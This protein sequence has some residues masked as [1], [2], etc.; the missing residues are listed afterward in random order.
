M[1]DENKVNR[2]RQM[3]AGGDNGTG[4]RDG[5][6]TVQDMRQAPSKPKFDTAPDVTKL[7]FGVMLKIKF[8]ALKSAVQH[9][10]LGAYEGLKESAKLSIRKERMDRQEM[11]AVPD[12]DLISFAGK[13]GDT[14]KVLT[15]QDFTSFS[16]QIGNLVDQSKVKNQ[17]DPE[18]F[19][20]NLRDVMKKMTYSESKSFSIPFLRKAANTFDEQSSIDP[21]RGMRKQATDILIAE[22]NRLKDPGGAREM[23][24]DLAKNIVRDGKE[25]T[26]LR[27]DGASAPLL[28]ISRSIGGIEVE[29]TAFELGK[30]L[31]EEASLLNDSMLLRRKDG[32]DKEL[33]TSKSSNINASESQALISMARKMINELDVIKPTPELKNFLG[34]MVQEIR[35]KHAGNPDLAN[36][37]INRLYCDQIIL[38]SI[39]FGLT[40]AQNSDGEKSSA[41]VLVADIIQMAANGW[42]ALEKMQSVAF[43]TELELQGG[44]ILTA[45]NDLL[46]VN[47]GMPPE[48]H[49]DYMPGEVPEVSNPPMNE[50]Q[51]Q[52]ENLVSKLPKLS[53]DVPEIKPKEENQPKPEVGGEKP[54]VI[55]E[56]QDK[57]TATI[58]ENDESSDLMM[59]EDELDDF[60]DEVSNEDG[61]E[62]GGVTSG[63]PK[64]TAETDDNQPVDL[65]LNTTD[66]K[67]TDKDDDDFDVKTDTTIDDG[68]IDEK[69]DKSESTDDSELTDSSWEDENARFW[70][71]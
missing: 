15:T 59:S 4:S 17:F 14:L 63:P 60:F 34:E 50:L 3:Q 38:R 67:K 39:S 64:T 54:L 1:I 13:S 21:H 25:R 66:D 22:L 45:L 62:Q 55:G 20:S 53:V 11:A 69:A 35:S 32:N 51:V 24:L 68:E 41:G 47:F 65:K 18:V 48:A 43:K 8:Q 12:Q 71:N 56:K 46:V 16:R 40:T 10:D 49:A 33:L 70:R 26:F 19:R 9:K 7:G 42:G 52:M 30:V 23:F 44:S 57:R 27:N 31:K 6:G 61:A 37:L 36:Q 5:L 58:K 28:F 29:A 2:F